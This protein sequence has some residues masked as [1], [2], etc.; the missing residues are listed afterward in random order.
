MGLQ[1]LSHSGTMVTTGHSGLC[2]DPFPPAPVPA[3]RRIVL[4]EQAVPE[5]ETLGLSAIKGHPFLN[6]VLVGKQ[7]VGGLE[8]IDQGTTWRV[9]EPQGR[10]EGTLVPPCFLSCNQGPYHE[11]N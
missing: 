4:L 7:R 3:L 2:G 1:S 10:A 5:L 11:Q 6:P 8:A 9:R